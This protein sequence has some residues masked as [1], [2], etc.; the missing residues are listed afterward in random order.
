MEVQ[1]ATACVEMVNTDAADEK[2]GK[3]SLKV[4]LGSKAE[5]VKQSADG[6]AKLKVKLPAIPPQPEALDLVESDISEEA[7]PKKQPAKRQKKQPQKQKRAR[8]PDEVW[9]I[10]QSSCCRFITFHSHVKFYGWC[11]CRTIE[12]YADGIL[13]C[14]TVMYALITYGGLAS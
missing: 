5:A 10:Y 4:K 8:T 6:A 1:S 11:C 14:S 13:Y 9:P 2:P 7:K 12:T 3:P